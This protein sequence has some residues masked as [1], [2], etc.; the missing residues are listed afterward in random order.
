[1]FRQSFSNFDRSTFS[2]QIES[3]N[4]RSSTELH[5]E[6]QHFQVVER[7]NVVVANR[8]D[9]IQ[10]VATWNIFGV[11]ID[12]W[13][14]ENRFDDLQRVRFDGVH[15]RRHSEPVDQVNVGSKLG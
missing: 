11:D 13:N 9:V 2:R 12:V 6:F 1:M 8:D 15:Q 10:N 7:G 3:R 14:V 5:N 4:G